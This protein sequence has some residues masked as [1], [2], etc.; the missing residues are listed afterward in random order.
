MITIL[1]FGSGCRFLGLSSKDNR[2]KIDLLIE[3]GNVATERT[4]GRTEIIV[5]FTAKK[6]VL[7]RLRYWEQQRGT[8]IPSDALITDCASRVSEVAF[9]EVL[10]GIAAKE[11]Y[12][13]AIESWESAAPD[14]VEIITVAEPATANLKN[15]LFVVRA[16]LPLRAA[17]VHRYRAK[18]QITEA[19]IAGMMPD[20]EGCLP[21]TAVKPPYQTADLNM[22]ISKI[23]TSGF[24]ASKIS[25]EDKSRITFGLGTFDEGSSW[26]WS[27][28]IDGFPELVNVKDIPIIASVTV[29]S[30]E[31]ASIYSPPQL[32]VIGSRSISVN[33]AV[34]LTVNWSVE[35]AVKSM[36]LFAQIGYEGRE[37]SVRCYGQSDTASGSITVPSDFLEKMEKKSSDLVVG[38]IGNQFATAEGTMNSKWLFQTH[39]F[40]MIRLEIE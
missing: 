16:N 30:E 5:R 1:M 39:D 15:D 9:D 38:L 13:I 10:R 22:R 34:D 31:S 12:Y 6:P 32:G 23:V 2:K 33:P 28:F 8:A 3:P 14:N 19:D 37:G 29:S 27:T 18:S 4:S 21:I 25:T 40:K 24:S 36:V 11:L 20:N 26:S 17:Q 35:G 7:C